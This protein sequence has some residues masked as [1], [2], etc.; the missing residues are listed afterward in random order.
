[1]EKQK[2]DVLTIVKLCFS[3]VIIF[4]CIKIIMILNNFLKNPVDNLFGLATKIAQE[5]ADDIKACKKGLLNG[6]CMVGLAFLY[7]IFGSG[8][9][10]LLTALFN[11]SKWGKTQTADDIEL[12]T[13]ESSVQSLQEETDANKELDDKFDKNPDLLEQWKSQFAEKMAGKNSGPDYDKAKASLDKMSNTEIKN[14]IKSDATRRRISNKIINYKKSADSKSIAS[15]VTKSFLDWTS[16]LFT[17]NDI[18][19]KAGEKA[20]GEIEMSELPKPPVE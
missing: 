12:H 13:G 6:Q 15:S 1:M 18:D 14:I 5:L 19:P 11:K 7:S 8:L 10:A 17:D 9:C 16:K 4:F 2:L 3:A 20:T